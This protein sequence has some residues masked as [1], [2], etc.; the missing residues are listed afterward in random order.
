MRSFLFVC[1]GNICR[2]PTAEAV[3]RE[4]VRAL[5]LD[6]AY[7]S[8]GT[9]SYHTGD[10]PDPRTVK[11]ASKYGVDMSDL[12]ARQISKKDYERFDH[13]IAMDAGHADIMYMQCPDEYKHKISML[14][15]YT[16]T[17]KKMDV[18]DPY[19]GSDKG[20]DRVYNIIEEGMDAL[21][22]A[23]RW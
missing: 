11:T 6:W 14:L 20:F 9:H 5:G 18:P 1:T 23:N 13:I 17:M 3:F 7:D 2:S 19:Y 16:Q 21:I 4:K 15:D 10:G 8:C 12:R 22:A